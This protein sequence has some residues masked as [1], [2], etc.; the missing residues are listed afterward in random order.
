[1]NKLINK[2]LFFMVLIAVCVQLFL[3]QQ[4]EVFH[5]D[6]LFSFA[7]ANGENGIYLYHSANEINDRVLSG[8]V[9]G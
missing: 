9:F 2:N 3:F 7:L 5:I 6:E 4:K 8:D 1:M